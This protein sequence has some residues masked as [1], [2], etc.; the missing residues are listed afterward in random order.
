MAQPVCVLKEHEGQVGESGDPLPWACVTRKPSH[1][2][3]TD[4]N[5][6]TSDVFP[7]EGEEGEEGG[8]LRRASRSDGLCRLQTQTD[9]LKHD[10]GPA[11]KVAVLLGILRRLA[12]HGR[13]VCLYS[14][15]GGQ[16]RL[17]ALGVPAFVSCSWQTFIANPP[18]HIASGKD[19]SF[20]PGHCRHGLASR[21]PFRQGSPKG[22][23]THFP[24]P[25]CPPGR[26]R[27][28]FRRRSARK[29]PSLGHPCSDIPC[30]RGTQGR[31]AAHDWLEVWSSQSPHRAPHHNLLR[32]D[33]PYQDHNP[34]S[35]GQEHCVLPE[36]SSTQS[37]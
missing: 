31:P 26:Q 35:T 27:T 15:R 16:G 4:R 6:N 3:R 20:P 32:T 23:L 12:G 5:C 36:I 18:L 30:R 10:S 28:T 8:G 33:G 11:S 24:T 22:L 37:C 14:P 19:L 9:K 29:L 34:C 25:Q 21:R 13:K 2:G 7:I 17:S 1:H